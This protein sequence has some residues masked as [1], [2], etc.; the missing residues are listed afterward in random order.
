M[1]DTLICPASNGQLEMVSSQRALQLLG[2]DLRRLDSHRTMLDPS[3]IGNEL[4]M[5]S[6]GLGAYPIANGIPI[7]MAPEMIVNV[8][9][10]RDGGFDLIDTRTDPFREAYAEMGFYNTVA[11]ERGSDIKKTNLYAHLAGLA[12]PEPFPGPS[13]I[14]SLYDH[15][16]QKDAYEFV[17]PVAA[18]TALQ[19]GGSGLHAVKFLLAGAAQSW[20]LTPMLSEAIIGRK[21]A[22]EFGVGDRFHAIVG[23]AEQMPFVDASIDRIYSGGSIHHTVTDRAFTDIHRVLATEGRFAAVEPW[24]APL[25]RLGTRIFGQR[26]APILGNRSHGVCCRPMETD[27]V[28]SLFTNF[29]HA[30]VRHHGTFSRYV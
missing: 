9:S 21:L 23:I 22:Q 7:L 8:E 16:A 29:T 26:E 1:S 20:L 11:A 17:A 25:Y 12:D 18:K 24:R 13:W 15:A 5:R 4:L 19:V 10:V 2:S 6:D 14:D 28:A 30:E 3:E 27:R